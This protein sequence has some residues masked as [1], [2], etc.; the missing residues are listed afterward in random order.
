MALYIFK[1]LHVVGFVSWFAGL[2]YL[3][4]IF[5]YYRESLDR[6]EEEKAILSKEFLAMQQRVYKIICN[7]AMM[8]TWTAGLSMLYIHGLEWLREN[9]WMHAKLGVLVLLTIYH[10]WCKK[11]IKLN[12]QG[13]SAYTP[14]QYRLLNEMPTLFLISIAFIAVFKNAVN[15]IYLIAGVV[16][17]GGLLFLAAKAYKRIRNKATK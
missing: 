13:I 6:P 7:P 14:F 2:F 11:Q 15:Y 12:E 4:R 5:V 3:V 9:Y 16:V 10:L 17:F 1:A 8:I